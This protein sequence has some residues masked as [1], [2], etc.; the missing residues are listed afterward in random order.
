MKHL[1]EGITEVLQEIG[2]CT[3]A[4]NA[5]SLFWKDQEA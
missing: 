5:A 2:N 4:A 3:C 1:A